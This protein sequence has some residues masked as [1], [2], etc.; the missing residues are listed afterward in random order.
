MNVIYA[1][2]GGENIRSGENALLA[3]DVSYDGIKNKISTAT[4]TLTQYGLF[5]WWPQEIKDVS[6]ATLLLAKIGLP[7]V[8]G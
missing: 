3:A 8:Q 7:L 2:L 4:V 6:N 5:A 1:E